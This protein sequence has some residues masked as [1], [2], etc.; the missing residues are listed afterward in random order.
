MTQNL[1]TLR[2][3]AKNDTVLFNI[4]DSTHAAQPKKKNSSIFMTTVN[5]V[6]NVIGEN[7]I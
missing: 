2:M 4:L 6:L 7:S 5:R 3:M 1:T